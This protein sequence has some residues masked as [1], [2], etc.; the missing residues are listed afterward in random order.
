MHL[1]TEDSAT[2]RGISSADMAAAMAVIGQQ[3]ESIQETVRVCWEQAGP[4]KAG[5][6][7]QVFLQKQM[8]L[9]LLGRWGALR[10]GPSSMKQI[11]LQP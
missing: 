2:P 5:R 11:L 4:D 8:A 1:R 7:D 6:L 10:P 9:F 3:V